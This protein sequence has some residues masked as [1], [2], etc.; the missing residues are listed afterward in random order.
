MKI[1]RLGSQRRRARREEGMALLFALGFLALMLIIGLGFVTTSLLAQKLAVN[2]SSRAQA[3]MFAR[4]AAARAMLNIMLYNDQAALTGAN[5]ENYDSICSYDR[6]AYRDDDT[7]VPNVEVIDT[8]IGGTLHADATGQNAVLNDQ[9]LKSSEDSSD[10]S[11]FK[12]TIGTEDYNGVGTQAKWLFF[13]DSP[14]GT[15]GRKIIGRAAFQVLPRHAGRF[16]LYAITGGSVVK[17]DYG[18]YPHT[19]RWGRDIAELDLKNTQTLRNWYDSVNAA[20]IPFKYDT[21]Y[22]SYGSFFSASPDV[23]KHWIEYWFAEGKNP[24]LKD[25][26]AKLDKSDKKNKK[27][28]YVNRF[29]ISDYYYEDA[30]RGNADNDNWYDR[31]KKSGDRN[32]GWSADELAQNKNSAEALEALTQ[33]AR[34]YKENHTEDAKIDPS[35]LPFLKRIGNDKG[36]FDSLEHLRKQI[37]ANFNDYCDADS[38]P[39]SDVKA[40]EWSI[41]DSGKYPNYTGNEK[42]LYINEVAVQ[43]GKIWI[44][45]NTSDYSLRIADGMDVR[46]LV[47]LVNMYDDSDE[48]PLLDPANLEL[49][50]KLEKLSF[51]IA[52][53]GKYTGRISYTDSQGKTKYVT[54]NNNNA[55]DVNS[56]YNKDEFSA[57]VSCTGDVDIAGAVQNA[58]DQEGKFS[59]RGKGYS[60][61]RRTVTVTATDPSTAFSN[62]V[63]TRAE[64]LARNADPAASNVKFSIQRVDVDYKI[65]LDGSTAKIQLSPMMLMTKDAVTVDGR[66]IAKGTGL[67]FVRFESGRVGEMP[68]SGTPDAVSSVRVNSGT[69]DAKFNQTYFIGGIEAKDPRQNL[70]PRY[71]A[72]GAVKSDWTLSPKLLAGSAAFGGGNGAP[73]LKLTRNA[74]SSDYDYE[75]KTYSTSGSESGREFGKVN[76]DGKPSGR[77]VETAD[78]E[79]ANDPAWLGENR[80]EHVS[81]AYIRNA[82]MVSPWEIGLIHRAG[83]WQTLNIKRAGGFGSNAEV[84]IKD[85]DSYYDNWTDPGTEYKNGDGAILEFVKVGTSCRCMGKVPLT[86]LRSEVIKDGEAKWNNI[87][88]SYNKD[89]IRMLFDGVRVGQTMKQFYAETKFNAPSSQGGTAITTTD[90][91]ITNFIE[92]ID[93]MYGG[94]AANDS[95][96]NK[97]FRMRSQFLNS[98]FGA[99]EGDSEFTFNLAKNYNDASREELIGKTINLLTVNEETPPNI[100]RMIV[101][102][103]SIRDIGGI[104]ADVTISKIHNGAEKSLGCQIGRF[105]FVSDKSTPKNW[106]NN[107]YFDEITGEVKALVTV[108]RVPATN[109]AN[110]ANTDFGRMVVTGFE[111]IE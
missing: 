20:N 15:E 93:D 74:G 58:D 14:E 76:S 108:E 10:E 25:A 48:Q 96:G 68:L 85:I 77:S 94:S 101:V 56:G 63:R 46:M 80:G 47:E 2:N 32:E 38:I 5:I 18:A 88:L 65:I 26:F 31:F 100:F 3:R 90:A 73:T 19:Y 89:V 107:T 67:D 110:E 105:D 21:L 33:D 59:K 13:Y 62:E 61:G 41:T 60:V 22:N 29:N 84:K 52:L 24:I 9:L 72:G 51:K 49:K 78:V 106:E 66:S 44:H 1:V 102:A 55:I 12:Y 17:N 39:T 81:T 40:A 43:I 99:N 34:S 91:A 57:E 95:D 16:S 69:P 7:K 87:G 50:F 75:V 98:N 104:G 103:Q 97:V 35:G 45:C 53:H 4:S 82:P 54:V 109:D 11:K 64:A 23:K 28:I 8:T 111:F 42:T 70:N 30:D 71:S 6:V 36:S 79:T 37:A 83:E 27:V 92:E 86:L